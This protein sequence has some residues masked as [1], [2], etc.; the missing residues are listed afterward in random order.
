VNLTSTPRA[1]QRSKKKS[2]TKDPKI[3]GSVD[4]ID[5]HVGAEGWAVDA[6]HPQAELELEL[7]AA[8]VRLAVTKT[9]RRRDDIA[10]RL[11]LDIL[12]GFRF[13]SDAGAAVAAAIDADP[14]CS[15]EVRAV[16][17]ERVLPNAGG[18]RIGGARTGLPTAEGAAEL[19][20]LARLSFLRGE[21]QALRNRALRPKPE[22]VCGYIEA[23]AI[24]DAG[25]TWVVGW[26]HR[27]Q[28]VDR[29]AVVLDSSKIA[30]GFAYALVPRDDL[31]ENAVGILGV[32]LTDWQPNPIT[33]SF[34]FISNDDQSYLETLSPPKLLTKKQLIEHCRPLWDRCQGT[35][36]HAMRRLLQ[37]SHSWQPLPEDFIAERAAVEEAA[38][39]PGFGWFLRGWIA[40]PTKSVERLVLKVG[41][42]IL[43]SDAK[44][45]TFT[46]RP[47]LEM[48]VPG[49]DLAIRR[50]GF[51]AVFRGE[52]DREDIGNALLKAVYCDGTASVHALSAGQVRI[53]GETTSI[54]R[55]FR[56]FPSLA[57]EPY[58]PDLAV[59]ARSSFYARVTEFTPVDVP[60]CQAALVFTLPAN[61]ADASLLF[62]TIRSHHA[63]LHPQLGI[64][65]LGEADG[66]R[67]IIMQGISDLRSRTARPVGLAFVPDRQAAAYALPNFLACTGAVHF[68]Y[69]GSDV[70]L[71]QGGWAGAETLNDELG[72]FEIVDP[73][74]DNEE[75]GRYSYDCFS[76]TAAAWTSVLHSTKPLL[77][78]PGTEPIPPALQKRGRLIKDAAFKTH[79]SAPSALVMAINGQ[80]AA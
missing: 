50:A 13:G 73:A 53:V 9:G 26:M 11:E 12:P 34:L 15:I 21:G 66:T 22:N 74:S 46:D 44:S 45:A 42:S 48:L 29:A 27:D 69:V 79:I 52:F 2:G 6:E 23:V 20:L 30:A 63:R 16:G 58:F 71:T 61:R 5:P 7:I 14:S 35:Y 36:V 65:I 76:W 55:A 19:G 64:L 18:D 31:P 78:G 68:L 60:Q 25:L 10:A 37:H 4:R 80:A 47:D 62:E 3:F 77:G 17:L 59:A 67:D 72:L 51:S 57:S 32:L 49:A 39:L 24:D 75:M 28:L 33:K 54:D 70:M 56:Y 41:H 43:L 38:A 8:G 1:T 40:S